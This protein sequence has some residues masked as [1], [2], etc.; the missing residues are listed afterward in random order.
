MRPLIGITS[1]LGRNSSGQPQAE[2]NAAYSRALTDAGAAPVVIPSDLDPDACAPLLAGLHGILFSG[3]GDIEPSRYGGDGS[4]RLIEVSPVRDELELRLVL[5]AAQSQTPFLGICRGCQVVNVALGGTLHEDLDANPVGSIRHN[6][7]GRESPVP[8]H[9][10][11]VE[12]DSA[13]TAIVNRQSFGVNSHHHQG[14]RQ[15]APLL[16]ISAKAPDGL[17][18][19][20]ELREHPFGLAVQWHP[21]WLTQQQWTRKLFA[22]FVAA[23]SQAR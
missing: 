9:D 12:A 5:L 10:V 18:E 14:L 19:A 11:L 20:V 23:A 3:G 21:E 2:L 15:I 22:A 1:D 4:A 8:A 7:P 17:V 6:V 16:R 13:L